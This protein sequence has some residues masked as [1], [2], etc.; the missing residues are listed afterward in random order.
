MEYGTIIHD[1]P[2]KNDTQK[3]LNYTRFVGYDQSVNAI[4][5][6]T[7]DFFS[8][9]NIN[10]IS[11]KVTE[12]TIGVHPENKQIVVPE[13][14]ILDVMNSVYENYTGGEVGAIYSR[15]IIPNVQ[16]ENGLNTWTNETINLLVS[17]IRDTYGMIE[18]NQKLTAWTTVYGDFNENGLR[19][20]APIKIRRKRPQPAQFNMN[21]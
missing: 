5:P 8:Q 12:L 20:H 11:T 14:W 3:N 21:Y 1:V 13:E 18:C 2:C 6:C 7:R 17:H 10:L 16:P 19:S 15:L 9:D 4:F